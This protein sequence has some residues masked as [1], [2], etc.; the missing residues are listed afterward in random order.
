MTRR[1]SPSS[2]VSGVFLVRGL[3]GED[4]GA[5]N[6]PRA[7]RPLPGQRLMIEEAVG[8][9]SRRPSFADETCWVEWQ[10]R[11]LS[12]TAHLDAAARAG[13]RPGPG[14]RGR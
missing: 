6:V 9:S 8:R 5:H 14:P 12:G 1:P 3:W 4:A 13:R 11:S 2:P 10:T 7:L